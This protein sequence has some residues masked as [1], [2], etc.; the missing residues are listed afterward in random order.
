MNKDLKYLKERNEQWVIASCLL[1]FIIFFSPSFPIF[2]IWTFEEAHKMELLLQGA[3][4][5]LI[6]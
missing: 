4:P 1:E 6:F 5:T 3:A 2:L